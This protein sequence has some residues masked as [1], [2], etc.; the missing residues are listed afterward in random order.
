MF[1]L[2]DSSYI[3]AALQIFN[4]KVTSQHLYGIL[5]WISAFN[6]IFIFR[7]CDGMWGRNGYICRN[8]ALELRMCAHELWE[9]YVKAVVPQV[10]TR[11]LGA[12]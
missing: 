9:D 5:I 4:A 10:P 12:K 11:E 8:L 2:W 3:P 1:L 6:L 7:D